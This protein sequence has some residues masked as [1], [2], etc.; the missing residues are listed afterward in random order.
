MR[1]GIDASNII[2]GGG[3]T[4]L[5]E[6]LTH[7]NPAIHQ[8]ES[9]DV[10]GRASVK[11]RF[12]VDRDFLSFHTPDA[13]NGNMLRRT[14]WSRYRFPTE[15]KNVDLVFAPGGSV[16][17]MKVPT[18]TMSQ[19]MLPFDVHERR[20]YG[21]SPMRLKFELLAIRQTAS[22]R[23]ANGLI[24]LTEY[25]KQT[26]SKV[27]RL[28]QKNVAVI[29]HGI[30]DHFRRPAESY[31]IREDYSYEKPFRFVYVSSIHRYKHHREV[32]TAIGKL[33]KEGF[34]IT[35]DLYG[36]PE[37]V[38][39]KELR[40][41]TTK[42]DPNSE[43]VHYHGSVPY[44]DLPGIYHDAD[45]FVFAST[46]ENLPIILLEAMASALPICCSNREPM[47]EVL[48]NAGDYFDAEDE[49]SI[50]ESLRRIYES[51]EQRRTY[52]HAA[53]ELA[54]KY[55]WSRC[56]DRTFEFLRTTY[57]QFSQGK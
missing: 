4:H 54:N 17:S 26:V 5:A 47:P 53:K 9:I 25:A 34:P 7:A 15:A 11:A 30:N 8:F 43:F 28:K 46:C 55:T 37:S 57:D 27:A 19:N 33:R 18:V 50:Y 35:L 6:L 12:P 29:P 40:L 38:A 10:W 32:V 3:L 23:N 49:H 44:A 45:A 13:L 48:R 20:R 39:L 22:F 51:A 31:P 42:A 41:A 21:W 16:R 52:S 24:F 56:A 14:H 36:R 2:G 1:I